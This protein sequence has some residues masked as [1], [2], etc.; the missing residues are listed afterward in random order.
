MYRHMFTLPGSPFSCLVLIDCCC[1]SCQVLRHDI[2]DKKTVGTVS[3]AYPHLIFDNFTSKLGVRVGN[4]LKHLF[5]VPKAD[6]KRVLTFANQ[7]CG[8]LFGR[9]YQKFISFLNNGDHPRCMVVFFVAPACPQLGSLC[10]MASQLGKHHLRS[11]TL[12]AFGTTR[13]LKMAVHPLW[14]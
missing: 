10:A 1:C 5:P 12:L 11:L 4:I 14:S 6:S 7:V 8:F 9:D 3:E 13:I 2:G